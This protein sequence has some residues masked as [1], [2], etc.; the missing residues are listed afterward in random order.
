MAGSE[1]IVE[2]RDG[3]D[4]GLGRKPRNRQKLEFASDLHYFANKLHLRDSC[5]SRDKL[6]VWD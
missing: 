2:P 4:S 1:L 5:S 3:E 6:G